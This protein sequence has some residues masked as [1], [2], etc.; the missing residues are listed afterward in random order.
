MGGNYY[1]V[2]IFFW[3][4]IAIT[5]NFHPHLDWVFTG[6]FMGKSIALLFVFASFSA[7]AV[8]S[9][10]LLCK[11]KADLF[12]R[13]VNLVV[14]SFEYRNGVKPDG[15]TN[16]SNDITF[17]FGG[18]RLNGQFDSTETDSSKIELQDN[19]GKDTFN[20]T[21]SI[22]YVKHVMILK[23]DFKLFGLDETAPINTK[24]KCEELN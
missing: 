18:H 16:R 3:H 6:D 11:G 1:Y 20:G 22:D 12:D 8:D 4:F 9:S 5:S 14:N 10:W 13:N 24:F 2:S 7:M 17:I 15:S 21:I 19:E 23:G